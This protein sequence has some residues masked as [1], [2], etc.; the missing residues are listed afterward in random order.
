MPKLREAISLA[1]A[2]NVINHLEYVVLYDAS[3][4]KNPDIP[5][6][7][8][9]DFILNEMS[10]D[11][12]KAEMSDDECKAKMSDDECKAEFRF[13]EN[14]I[15]NLIDVLCVPPEFTCYNGLKVNAIEAMC[16]FLKRFAYP[17]RYVD[18]IQRFFRPEPQLC[19]I[20]NKMMDIIYQN[21]NHLFINLDQPWLDNQHLENFAKAFI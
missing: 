18:L 15:Y 6:F 4:A 5:Y 2:C 16:V 8:Y 19:M 9:E 14:D 13:Y 12:C 7:I 11:E 21:W 1:Y 20:A 17:C 10:D 3:K